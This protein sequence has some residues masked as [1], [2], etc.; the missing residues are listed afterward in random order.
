MTCYPEMNEKIVSILRISDEPAHLYAADRIE[1]L[2]KALAAALDTIEALE[3]QNAAMREALQAVSHIEH[4][5]EAS[6]EPD[7]YCLACG[8]STSDADATIEHK[9]ECW[10]QTTLA[11]DAGKAILDEVRLKRKMVEILYKHYKGACDNDYDSEPWDMSEFEDWAREA[12][13]KEG[14]E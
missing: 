7:Y 8:S 11:A 13:A 12:L 1:E 4:C 5:E 6:D 10:I 9:P 14:G 3:A 2:E